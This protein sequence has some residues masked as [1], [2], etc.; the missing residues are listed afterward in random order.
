MHFVCFTHEWQMHLDARY[1]THKRNK[2]LLSI[3]LEKYLSS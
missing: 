1:G 3:N 2:N